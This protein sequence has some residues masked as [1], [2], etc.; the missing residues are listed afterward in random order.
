[1]ATEVVPHEKQELA[2][3]EETRPGRRFV[4]RVDIHETDDALWLWADLPGV[5]EKSVDVELENGELSI[6]GRVSLEGYESLSPVYTEYNVG[7]YLRNFRLSDRI[8]VDRIEAKMTN[9]VLELQLPKLA[10]AKP[11]QIPISVG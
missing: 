2:R 9:G 10:A 4:P 3:E 11:R 6:Q 5:D 1:M 7:H 8:D